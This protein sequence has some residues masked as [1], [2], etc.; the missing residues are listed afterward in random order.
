MV[1]N[2]MS[3][4]TGIPLLHFTCNWLKLY[5]GKY[6]LELENGTEKTVGTGGAPGSILLCC[7][8]GVAERVFWC[9]FGLSALGVLLKEVGFGLD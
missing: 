1:F 4:L 6:S 9:W 5:K 8:V 7:N 3:L 2:E